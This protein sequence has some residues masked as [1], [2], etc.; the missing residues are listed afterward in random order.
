M[1]FRSV[2]AAGA[3][4]ALCHN[5]TVPTDPNVCTAASASVNN[6]SSDPDGEAVTVS[7]APVGPYHLGSTSPVTLTVKDSKGDL[8][9]CS[10]N[11]TVVDQQPPNISC[12][13]PVGECTSPSGASV[14]FSPTVSDNCPG[15]QQPACVPPSGSVFPLGSTPF[16]CSVADASGNSNSC[17]SVVKV[18]DT[19]PPTISSVSPN[20]AVLWPPNHKFVSVK[21]S[22][23]VKDTCDPNPV[24]KITGIS[25]N[26]PILRP[27]SGHTAPDWQITGNLTANL[28]AERS[29][30]GTGRIY[31]L[32]V[33]CSDA[34]HNTSSSST[35]VRVP[36]DK[37]RK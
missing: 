7:Q 23:I 9:F 16:S 14:T 24:C 6:G 35:T 32:A 1:Y 10:A 2:R 31:T 37:G 21:V 33:Q 20:P 26:E 34:S 36:H 25:S 18:Q 29:G 27:G 15:V 13:A 11:V 8:D 5:V 19:T 4:Q 17:S 22:I 30:T 28:R 3:P 12:P